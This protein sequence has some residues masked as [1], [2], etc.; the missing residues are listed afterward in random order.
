[1]NM[2]TTKKALLTAILLAVCAAGFHADE[3][4]QT[5]ILLDT[6]S[7]MDGLIAQ[8]KTKLWKI[9]NELALAKRN[10][11]SPTLEVAVYEY[12]NDGLTAATGYI[13]QVLP[14]TRD[15]DKV[16]ESLFQL[17][18][19]GGSEYCGQVIQRA[20][21]DLAWSG[22]TDVLK[23][24]YIAGNEG[25]NQGKVDYQ[26]ACREAIAKGIIV[27]TIF[28]GDN[29]QGARTFWLAGAQ[30]ADGQ[31]FSIDQNAVTAYI[32]A[33][34]DDQILKLNADLNK[35]YL[36]YGSEGEAG[37]EL[38]AAQDTNAASSGAGVIV[39]RSIAKSKLQYAN[40]RWDLVDA[41]NAGKVDPAQLKQEELPPE[42]RNKTP[43]QQRAVIEAK[44]RER[45]AIQIKISD[46]EKERREYI[47]QEQKA[48]GDKDT[49]DA[50]ILKSVRTQAGKQQYSFT[51]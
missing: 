35:T 8:A 45:A 30:L 50:A 44:N 34:Q 15:L 42:L 46:L 2:T 23:L 20:A 1:M 36:A 18:T 49:L 29:A 25:F 14:L 13:R 21:H 48:A 24:V 5:A 17:S 38:Q 19:N 41:V 10:G 39:E 33:P 32:K 51:E 9:V 16:S 6:S 47:A 27:N 40:E 4:I 31:Y 3:L 22:K 26:A 43:E 28:C 7:S 11:A 37:R 12:G